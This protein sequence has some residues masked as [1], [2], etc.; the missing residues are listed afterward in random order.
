MKESL[1]QRLEKE[2][3]GVRRKA[4]L[5]IRAHLLAYIARCVC[6]CVCVFK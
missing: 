3:D 6:V 2:R 5:I 4:G 1:E